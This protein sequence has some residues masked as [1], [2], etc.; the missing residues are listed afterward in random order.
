MPLDTKFVFLDTQVFDQHHLDFQSPKLMRLRRLA[1]AEEL[2]LIETDVT[3]SEVRSHIPDSAHKT[4]KQISD[5]DKLTRIAKEVISQEDAQGVKK[6][7]EEAVVQRL[8]EDLAKFLLVSGAQVLPIDSVSPATIFRKYFEAEPPF[9]DKSKK[10]EFPDAFAAAALESWCAAER[11]RKLYIVSGDGDWRRLCTRVNS[12]IYVKQLD[13]LLELFADA[14]LAAELKEAIRGRSE[15]LIAFVKDEIEGG[16]IYFYVDESAIDGWVDNIENVD[17]DIADIY[18]VEAAEGAA[19]LT[20]AF[21]V[22][23]ELFVTADD[24]DS[25]YSDPDTHELR[26][27]YS[28]SGT[29]EREL[30]L[31]ATVELTY[32]RGDPIRITIQKTFVE[33]EG[34][35]IGIEEGELSTD[36]DDEEDEP[37]IYV[38][39]EPE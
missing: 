34:I 5:F 12:F 39:D 29:V 4:V 35:E 1:M 17:V 13:Q 9:D 19:T 14:E 11:D 27:V 22:K 15:E 20:L 38:A 18:V 23:V 10:V 2:S 25:Q 6:V 32:E 37:D 33:E 31:E 36:Y 21:D 28:A 3:I 30:E 7:P 26:S 16:K 24:P 8:Q